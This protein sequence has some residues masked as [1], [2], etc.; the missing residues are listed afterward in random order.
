M[1]VRV[2]IVDDHKIVRQAV[3]VVLHHHPEILVVGE[4]VD[5]RSAV[6]C[7]GREQPD[8]VLMDVFLPDESGFHATEQILARYPGTRVVVLSATVNAP[9]VRT[10]LE[11]GASGYVGKE[12]SGDEILRAVRAAMAGRIYLSPH[13]ARAVGRP[14]RLHPPVKRANPRRRDERNDPISPA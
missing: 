2:V 13:A 10:A 11:L 14:R 12:E 5:A 1:K 3:G 4:A 7:V 9:M 6:D 8:L